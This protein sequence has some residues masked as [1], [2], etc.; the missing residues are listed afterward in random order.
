MWALNHWLLREI[1]D[2]ELREPV[3]KRRARNSGGP[4]Q[5]LQMETLM[6]A[7]NIHC[8]RWV[9]V[10]INSLINECKLRTKQ[11]KGSKSRKSLECISYRA[12][13]VLLRS[14]THGLKPLLP[15]LV[16]IWNKH[17]KFLELFFFLFLKNVLELKKWY[18]I[19]RTNCIPWHHTI[20][21]IQ[22]FHNF[23]N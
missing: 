19:R 20:L 11:P 15:S 14:P 2:R 4:R 18:F 23:L 10:W 7:L 8:C 6:A 22:C 3:W 9:W 1:P 17:F 12:G 16:P 21:K 5:L 13:W